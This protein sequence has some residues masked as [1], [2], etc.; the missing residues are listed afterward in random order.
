[1]KKAKGKLAQVTGSDVKIDPENHYDSWAENYD[2]ELLDQ[3]GYCAHK[4]AVDAF[5]K[6]H[7]DR[8]APVIDV[9]CGT[10]LVGVEL[11]QIGYQVIDGVDVS[12]GMLDKSHSL[13]IYRK[14]FHGRIG[15]DELPILVGYSGVLC[16][17]SFGL[18]HM[19]Q[20]DI[21]RLIEMAMPKAPIV[22]F[23][24]AEPFGLEGYTSTLN[25]LRDARL[26]MI[27]KL[28]DHNYMSALDRPGKL[29]V[30]RRV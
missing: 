9:G 15:S 14:L 22:I 30:G 4:I 23:M 18:G 28:E 3:Y 5:S 11:A 24:N 2:R 13:G 10:G 7:S 21:E 1:M 26:W 8:N 17:G 19:G 29:I 20:E 25:R 12:R 6:I 16:V 27:E